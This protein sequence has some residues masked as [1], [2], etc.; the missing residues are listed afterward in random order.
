MTTYP[1]LHT[2]RRAAVPATKPRPVPG[3]PW[4]ARAGKGLVRV[5]VT[6]M[7]VLAAAA[8]LFL[9]VGPRVLGYQTS[10]MLTGSMSPMI[11]PGDVVVSVPTNVTDLKVGDVITYHI[12]VEDQRVETHRII[13][14]TRIPEGATSIRTK[15][16]ANNGA[17]PWTA[18]LAED[19]AYTTAAVIPHLGEAIRALRSPVVGKVLLNG[20]P[21]ALV[22]VLLSSIWA[23][24]KDAA[25]ADAA[26]ALVETGAGGRP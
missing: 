23:R 13:E 11:N 5:L 7:L 6:G 17:D 20:A 10:T 8:F 3:R 26:A 2:G 15:G 25:A 12:P 19:Q 9:A 24:P 14:I 18:T 4:A 16:D 21:A 22:V 1:L